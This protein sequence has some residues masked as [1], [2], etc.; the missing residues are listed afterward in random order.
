VSQATIQH[1]T[2]RLAAVDDTVQQLQRNLQ[3]A[4]VAQALTPVDTATTLLGSFEDI[5]HHDATQTKDLEPSAAMH[6]GMDTN[7]NL[8]ESFPR[9]RSE[10]LD[11]PG[12]DRDLHETSPVEIHTVVQNEGRISVYGPSSTFH[13]PNSHA[14]NHQSLSTPG[15]SNPSRPRGRSPFMEDEQSTEETRCR[16]FANSALQL[17]KEWTYMTE[18]RFDLDGLDFDTAWH[19]LQLH[20]NHHHLSY[21][22]TYRPAII[23]SL[24]TGGPYVNKL[25]L[26]SIY[27]SSALNSDR[28]DLYDDPSDRQSL[29]RRFF[30]RIQQLVLPDLESSSIPS[31]VALIVIGSSLVSNGRQTAGWFYSGLGYRMMI[32]LG[33]HVN[34]HK[35]RISDPDPSQPQIRFTDVDLEL[36]RR[37]YWGAYINDKFQSL[38]FGRPPALT[39]VGIE[40]SRTCLDS[41]EELELWSPYVDA[42]TNSIPMAYVPQPAYTLST[43][44][45]FIQLA[46]I[47]SDVIDRLYSPKVQFVSKCTVLGDAH[48][49]QKKLDRWSENLPR[50]LR[51]DPQEGAVPPAHRFNPP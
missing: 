10:Q 4:Q 45:S 36:Q 25:L 12:N 46:E 30:L 32:D 19:L 48:G 1:L 14:P 21:L 26:N 40:P 35:L 42:K 15:G 3:Q 33:L 44:H 6:V 39:A 2:A 41:F 18:R 16:L 38:Y 28:K 47:M 43:F 17:Q 13:V 11:A 31:A 8:A 5:N 9:P 29:G 37:V 23:H 49:L 20:W 27:F 50:H 7:H 34:A 22:L 51:C 24:A